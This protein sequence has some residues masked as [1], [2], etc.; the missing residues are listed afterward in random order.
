MEIQMTITT[1]ELV[2]Y[3]KDLD[4]RISAQPLEFILKKINNAGRLLSSQATCFY[5]KDIYPLAQYYNANI[6]KFDINTAKEAI[7][8]YDTRIVDT[9]TLEDTDSQV[10]FVNNEDKTI[11]VSIPVGYSQ[12]LNQSITLSYFYHLDIQSGSSFDIDYELIDILKDFISV[13]IWKYLKDFN[14]AD[15]HQKQADIRLSR[16]VQGMPQEMSSFENIKGGF[17]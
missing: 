12:S 3:A 6:L 11:T 14:K 4:S 15:Y 1:D 13:E 5:S 16:R 9:Y 17:L 2:E 8:I 10:T 7:Y